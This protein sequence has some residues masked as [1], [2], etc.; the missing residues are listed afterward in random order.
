MLVLVCACGPEGGAAQASG[1]DSSSSGDGSGGTSTGTAETSTGGAAETPTGGTAE[2]STGTG[3]LDPCRALVGRAACETAG[4]VFAEG[5]RLHTDAD[6]CRL[7]EMFGFCTT[8]NGGFQV[9]TVFYGP[10]PDPEVVWFPEKLF[11]LPDEDWKECDC[12]DPDAPLACTC[13]SPGDQCPEKLDAHCGTLTDEASC[14]QFKAPEQ[15]FYGCMWTEGRAVARVDAACSEEALPGRCVAMQR[16]GDSCVDDVPPASC[17]EMDAQQNPHWRAIDGVPPTE[18]IE[19]VDIACDVRPISL[20]PCWGALAEP[21][22]CEC[23][24]LPTL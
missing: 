10:G 5:P 24:C 7:G 3:A 16:T 21:A 19:L 8:M 22:A 23:P 20:A 17:S 11:E 15:L 1:T 6:G 18:K 2:T 13:T 12:N 14:A 4:C 9:P